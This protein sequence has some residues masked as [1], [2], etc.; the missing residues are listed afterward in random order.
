MLKQWLLSAIRH[1][2]SIQVDTKHHSIFVVIDTVVL[3]VATE[4]IGR[5]L[6][7]I[8]IRRKRYLSSMVPGAKREKEF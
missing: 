7:S 3:P 4:P 5:K 1:G 2:I 6:L 8:T